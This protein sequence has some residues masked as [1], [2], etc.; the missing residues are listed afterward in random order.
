VT[1]PRA[2]DDLTARGRVGRLRALARDA[3]SE[4]DLACVR[5]SYVA[6]AFN[7]VF[8]VEGADGTTDAL[9][10]SPNLRIHADGCEAVEAAW[11]AA[12]RRDT[13]LAVPLVVPTR[14]GAPS[15]NVARPGVPGVRTC[16]LFEWVG[17]RPLRQCMRGPHVHRVGALTAVVHEHGASYLHDPPAG[18]LTADRVLYFRIPDRLDELDARYGSVIREAVDRAQ[19]ALDALWRDPPHRPHLLH[20]DVQPGNVMVHGREVVLIDFQDLIW[21]LEIQDAL[22]ALCAL[23][24]FDDAPALAEA[25]RSGY[26]SVRPWPDA[27]A[28]TTAAVRAARH[29]NILNFGLSPRRADLEPFIARHVDPV[30]GWMR[31]G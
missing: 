31:A 7:T 24:H 25:F 6:Q 30:V 12:L 4:Y 10:V 21:G 14:D 16:V 13:G 20:G 27:D 19:R 2:F 3:L 26:E 8:R 5:V 29:L 18:A 1:G 17:G 15:A 9:R 11:V 23:E 22:F 28:E